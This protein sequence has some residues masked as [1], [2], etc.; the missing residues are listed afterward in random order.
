MPWCDKISPAPADP[1]ASSCNSFKRVDSW[2]SADGRNIFLVVD[3]RVTTADCL[4]DLTSLE[5]SNPAVGGSGPS[6]SAKFKYGL[7]TH[8]TGATDRSG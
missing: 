2:G 5:D 3:E 1:A 7:R 6:R 4:L 8:T